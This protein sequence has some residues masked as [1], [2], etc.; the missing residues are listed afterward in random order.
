MAT[1]S[2][3][4]VNDITQLKAIGYEKYKE[5]EPLIEAIPSLNRLNHEIG[6]INNRIKELEAQ[7]QVNNPAD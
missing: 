5:R 4:D 7:Q 2:L 1:I 3:A 6:L